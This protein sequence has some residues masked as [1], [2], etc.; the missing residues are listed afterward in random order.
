MVII[1]V[2]EKGFYAKK[3]IILFANNRM[4]L[5]PFSSLPYRQLRKLQKALNGV[6]S[7]SLPYRQLRKSRIE[8]RLAQRCSLPYRQLRNCK[9]TV[10]STCLGSLPYRQLRKYSFA[11]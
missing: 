10:E 5:F 8:A 9:A 11:R 2:P 4:A 7:C 1:Y 6:C 3:L